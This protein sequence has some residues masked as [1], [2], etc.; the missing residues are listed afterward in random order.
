MKNEFGSN[1]N[2]QAYLDRV[3]CFTDRAFY[4]NGEIKVFLEDEDAAKNNRLRNR[5]LANILNKA[6]TQISNWKKRE[7]FEKS[8]SDNTLLLF[9]SVPLEIIPEIKELI[10]CPNFSKKL[11]IKGGYL[12]DLIIEKG[13][14]L[15]DNP[16]YSLGSRHTQS[17][18]SY[19]GKVALSVFD[20]NNTE[21][22]VKASLGNFAL[23]SS[24]LNDITKYHC[25]DR[26]W[27]ELAQ[28][29]KSSIGFL[30]VFLG[31]KKIDF[32]LLLEELGNETSISGYQPPKTSTNLK[33]NESKNRIE[34][35]ANSFSQPKTKATIDNLWRISLF[36]DE[37]I[38]TWFESNVIKEARPIIQSEFIRCFDHIFSKKVVDEIDYLLE[39]Q[40]KG[41]VLLNFS[42]SLSVAKPKIENI[43][44]EALRSSAPNYFMF[45]LSF[46]LGRKEFRTQK[47]TNLEDSSIVFPRKLTPENPVSTKRLLDPQYESLLILSCLTM[48][49]LIHP[50]ESEKIEFMPRIEVSNDTYELL[51]Q[52]YEDSKASGNNGTFREFL[53]DKL[54]S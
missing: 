9:L 20:L 17:Q 48:L 41:G 36:V 23:D 47:I 51:R 19:I 54:L 33:Y 3:E 34:S 31:R 45:M 37:L 32:N 27:K 35:I 22:E 49:F 30:T 2:H 14:L 43:H 21:T 38:S 24:S 16:F 15:L 46:A 11:A 25:L 28:R 53:E 12:E 50:V 39:M 26:L 7:F 42:E 13:W 5:E 29:C 1:V 8:L 18:I 52:K 4:R 6:G 10:T 44:Y 40:I